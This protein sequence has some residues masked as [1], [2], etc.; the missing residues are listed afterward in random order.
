MYHNFDHV[1]ITLVFNQ[2]NIDLGSHLN[3]FYLLFETMS[4]R[5]LVLPEV[6][7]H[8]CRY[9]YVT[10]LHVVHKIIM[11]NFESIDIVFTQTVTS[12]WTTTNPPLPPPPPPRS[13]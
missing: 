1:I 7:K 4:E 6:L 9:L 13:L 5:P 10:T 2:Y 8:T 11:L 12:D 3:N